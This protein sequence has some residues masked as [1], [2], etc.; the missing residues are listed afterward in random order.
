MRQNKV[1]D[2]HESASKTLAPSF[3]SVCVNIYSAIFN[4]QAG[5]EPSFR[6]VKSTF[7]RRDFNSI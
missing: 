5:F 6:Q 3:F 7:C 4:V 2:M 1:H